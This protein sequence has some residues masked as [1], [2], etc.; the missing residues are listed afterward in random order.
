[1]GI[2]DSENEE[3]FCNDDVFLS[4]LIDS[5]N[6]QNHLLKSLCLIFQ[7]YFSREF[8]GGRRMGIL[9]EENKNEADGVFCRINL[10]FSIVKCKGFSDLLS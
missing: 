9:K 3:D 8:I 1:M 10:P 5:I 6:C 7:L 2:K 4:Y